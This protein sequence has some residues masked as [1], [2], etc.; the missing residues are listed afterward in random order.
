MP[1]LTIPVPNRTREF[2]TGLI[3]QWG[4]EYPEGIGDHAMAEIMEAVVTCID[5]TLE[6]L[7]YG[8]FMMLFQIIEER[9]HNRKRRE[10]LSGGPV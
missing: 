2:L 5:K 8:R 6:D 3:E 9:Y 10:R 7:D 1:I 4:R